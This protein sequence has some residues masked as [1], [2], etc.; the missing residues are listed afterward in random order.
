MDNITHTLIGAVLGQAGL[1]RRSG[2]A[3]P[4]LMI[5][6]NLPDVDAPC[7]VY[8]VESLAMRRGIT[9]G[10][11]ALLVLPLVLAA[12]LIAFDRWQDRRG[13]RP[14][15][16]APVH[17]GWLLVLC[18]LGTFTHPAFD[19]LNSYG[20]RLLEPFSSRWFYGDALFIV[21]PWLLAMLALGLW[22]SRRRERA[23]APRWP[24]AA[25]LAV[26]G[27]VAYVVLNIGISRMASA[28]VL[29]DAP[30]PA[31]ALANPVPLAFWRRDVLWRGADGTYGTIACT[32]LRC[33]TYPL[34]VRRT[35]M[36]DP[37]IAARVRGDPA[38]AAFLFWS[39]MPV[40]EIDGDRLVL[41]DQRFLHAVVRGSFRVE[42]PPR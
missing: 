37:R 3:M 31:V 16:R 29:G 15:G 6:A 38:A 2:L 35:H 28:R 7:V 41:K 10:P 20:I 25:Q 30:Y 23:G 1:K 21:D 32:P 27:V 42:L 18:Y 12:L 17:P 9:H 13:T 19:W 40:A 33:H 5:A 8:G 39:R 26:A 24:G 36:D 22:L 34:T 4:A 11:V 14:P